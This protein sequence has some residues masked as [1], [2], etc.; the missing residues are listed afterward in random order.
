[1]RQWVD[2]RLR[3]TDC[4]SGHRAST[5]EWRNCISVGVRRDGRLTELVEQLGLTMY[6]SLR[7]HRPHS[8][9]FRVL[10]SD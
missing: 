8:Y 7:L 10:N 3:I 2:A 5:A 1:M 4:R 9:R 6:I